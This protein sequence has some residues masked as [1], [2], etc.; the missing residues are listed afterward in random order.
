MQGKKKRK[1][2]SCAGTIA[3]ATSFFFQIKGEVSI[4]TMGAEP[5]KH[6]ETSEI[7]GYKGTDDDEE[8][9]QLVDGSKKDPS[10]RRIELLVNSGLAEVCL[11]FYCTVVLCMLSIKW[12]FLASA[13]YCGYF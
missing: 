2:T 4:V 13:F 9:L 7:V 5:K 3:D 10:L 1:E 11:P 6:E 8:S 12:L